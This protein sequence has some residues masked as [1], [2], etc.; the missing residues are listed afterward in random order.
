MFAYH[1]RI[2]VLRVNKI[3]SRFTKIQLE[4]LT[5]DW[6]FLR[7]NNHPQKDQEARTRVPG[8]KPNSFQLGVKYY[9]Q[10]VP[11]AK[12]TRKQRM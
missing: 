5:L 2:K 8:K 6:C 1:C 9:V 10:T 12:L 4:F 3:G 7:S 11:E